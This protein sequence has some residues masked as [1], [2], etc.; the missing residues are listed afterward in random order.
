[1]MSRN[2]PIIPQPYW[3]NVRLG[4]VNG[5][6]VKSNDDMLLGGVGGVDDWYINVHMYTG[7]LVDHE[8]YVCTFAQC[9]VQYICALQPT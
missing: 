8:R 7:M 5:Y 3:M 1:M 6:D 9:T 2:R 4:T